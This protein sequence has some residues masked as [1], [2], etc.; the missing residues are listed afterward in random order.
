MV[1][2]AATRPCLRRI[3]PIP[4]F[5]GSAGRVST[6]TAPTRHA[7]DRTGRTPAA[8]RRARSAR[9]RRGADPRRRRRTPTCVAPPSATPR[10]I[11]VSAS[12]WNCSPTLAPL[13]NETVS[14]GVPASNR[15]PGGSVNRSS[16][17][18]SQ[19][20]SGIS[21][22]SAPGH[23]APR[24]LTARGAR[25]ACAKCLR[26]RLPAKAD[27]EDGDPALVWAQGQQLDFASDPRH[28]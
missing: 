21:S 1:S 20:P 2:L 14:S 6:P 12:G 22:G 15:A 16:C 19:G 27:P 4:L 11:P 23:G 9:S 18:N 17:Q 10:R 25:H 28:V 7:G 24:H 13:T 3:R 5:S 8:E 26:Q